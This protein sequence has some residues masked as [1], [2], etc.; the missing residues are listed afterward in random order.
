MLFRSKEGMKFYCTTDGYLDQNGGEKDFPFGKRRFSNIIK[1][2]HDKS[3]AN[4]QTVFLDEILKYESIIPNNDRNDDIT[5][6]AFE[7]GETSEYKEKK[8]QEIVKYEGA[9]TQ[10][11]IASC[12]DNIES[13]INN[14][15]TMSIISTITIEYCQNIMKYIKNEDIPSGTIEVQYVNNEYY[16]ITATNI[17]FSDDKKIIEPKL[18]EIKSLDKSGIKK[19]YK[20]LRRTGVNTHENGGGIGLYEIAKV[21]DHI[22]YEFK[23]IGEQKYCFT[24]KSFVKLGTKQILKT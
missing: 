11:V 5:L 13:K 18:Q 10:N 6:I 7:I 19:R 21:S 23:L 12:M 15:N 17:I 16:I 4:Q 1:E 24:M 14:M 9:M 20:E 8:V 22:E 2:Y 3:M